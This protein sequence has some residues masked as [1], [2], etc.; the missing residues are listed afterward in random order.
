MSLIFEDLNKA[1][2]ILSGALDIYLTTCAKLRDQYFQELAT[3]KLDELLDRVANE[4]QLVTSYGA[5]LKHAEALMK[6]IR[7]STPTIVPINSLPSE[8]LIRIF[9]IV[10]DAQPEPLD[11]SGLPFKMSLSFPKYPE[12]L[13]Q[14]CFKWRQIAIGSHALW[15]RIDLVLHHPLGP[16][17]LARAK[18]HVSRSGQ[19]PLDVRMI[20]PTLGH[21]YLPY[22]VPYD[23][24]DFAFL[25]FTQTPMNAL[26]L[27]SY[28]GLHE[29]HYDFIH[30]C[31]LNCA[32]KTLKKL[33]IRNSNDRNSQ[34]YFIESGYNPQYPESLYVNLPVHSLDSI[35][36]STTVLHLAGLYPYWTSQGYHQLV[37]LRLG[38]DS[39]GARE[40]IS[41][42]QM[43]AI[44]KASPRLRIF[45]LHLKVNDA[46]PENTPTSAIRLDELESLNLS[47][48]RVNPSQVLRF[49]TPGQKPLQLSIFGQPTDVVEH[50][51]RSSNVTQLRLVAWKGYPLTNALCLCPS[52]QSLVLDVWG[53]MDGTNF[54]MTPEPGDDGAMI[55]PIRLRSLYVLRCEGIGLTDLKNMVERHSIQELTLWRTYP[56]INDE[57]NSQSRAAYEFEV[58]ALCPVVK[59]LGA[60]QRNPM[61]DWDL[62]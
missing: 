33:V 47:S 61:D 54:Q 18:A 1:S 19:L 2:T 17:F 57:H 7:N 23:F 40:S 45:H 56:M 38:S 20:D 27:V 60:R 46:L 50:F 5:K 34:L 58:S 44:L 55:I 14:V 42:A 53:T 6:V 32:Q 43:I 62:F 37:D 51:L 15:T 8:I 3:H 4:L 35:W 39:T 52:L 13:S 24:N 49:I 16:G 36:Y 25:T 21:D 31:I 9:H 59:Y 29:E 12:I 11:A 26:S 22:G 48:F 28:H 10:V 30:Y 41:E